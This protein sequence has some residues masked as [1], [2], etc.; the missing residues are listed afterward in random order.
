MAVHIG[1][2]GWSYDHWEGVLYPPGLPKTDRLG[3]Y[4]QRFRTVEINSTFYRWPGTAA[5]ARWHA[6][7]PAEF[8]MTVK[9]PRGLTHA[10]RL[11]APER[12]LERIAEGCDALEGNLGVLLVQLPPGM[13]RDVPRL[14]YF[15]EQAPAR[16]RIALEVRDASWNTEEVF[17]L[18]ERHG[19]AYCVMSGAHLPCILKATAKFAYVRMHGPDANHL[20]GGSYSDDD[21]RW[22]RDRIAEWQG[23]GLDVWVYFNNDGGGNAVR[24]AD[25][26]RGLVGD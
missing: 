23:A 7:L 19:A 18:L 1:T 15:L 8:L 14:A 16:L 10:A 24:N 9:A 6:R 20:Y 5:F 4:V 11:Y 25:T 3:V 21:L 17:A 12:W 22:W 13:E 2:S 26:L